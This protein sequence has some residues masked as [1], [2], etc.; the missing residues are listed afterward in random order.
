[1][2]EALPQTILQTYIVVKHI[3]HGVYVTQ[4]RYVSLSTSYLSLSFSLVRALRDQK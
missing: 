1:M 2:F 4:L 3:Y